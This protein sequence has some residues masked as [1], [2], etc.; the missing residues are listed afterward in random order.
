MSLITSDFIG[1]WYFLKTDLGDLTNAYILANSVTNNSEFST[2]ARDFIQGEAG[3]LVIDQLG[4]KEKCTVSGNA[5]IINNVNDSV[6]HKSYFDV[7]DLLLDDYYTLLNFL[8][9]TVEDIFNSNNL[10]LYQQLLNKLGLTISNKNLLS[11]ATINI[12]QHISC[13]LNYNTRYD[14]KFTIDYNNLT[15]GQQA[16]NY[17]FIAREAKNYDC[18]FYLDGNEYSIK[19][20]SI[21]IN[22][23]YSEVYIGNT[24]NKL[25]FYSPQSH[26]VSGSI[27]ILAPHTSYQS[28]PVSGNISLLIGD[29]YIEL[30]QASIKS[31][32]TRKIEAGQSVSTIS[33]NFVAYARLGAGISPA[34]WDNYLRYRLNRTQLAVYGPILENFVQ[35]PT[36]EFVQSLNAARSYL[37]LQGMYPQSISSQQNTK[38]GRLQ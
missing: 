7:V 32:Y 13:T 30:G 31:N 34:R 36:P 35:T 19:S 17:D 25:P 27:E 8:F 26:S 11:S 21:N 10:D 16:A 5:L 6:N 29:R 20:G 14:S 15:S 1:S 23:G 37:T 4:Q 33:I 2:Q 3:V 28:L 9:I 22:I 24:L 38:G 18:R 12:G